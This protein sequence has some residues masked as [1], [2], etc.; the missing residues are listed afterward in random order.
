MLS[1]VVA[2]GIAEVG[3]RIFCLQEVA[4]IRF[5]YDPQRGEIPTPNQKGRQI[6]PG[7]Y[8]FTYSNNSLGLR[9]SPIM[10]FYLAMAPET[11][12][13]RKDGSI[14]HD[15]AAFTAII[16]RQ[17]KELRSLTPVLAASAEPL[18][19]LYFV[20]RDG[21]WTAMG[22]ALEAQYLGAEIERRLQKGQQPG[23]ANPPIFPEPEAYKADKPHYMLYYDNAALL[24]M[25]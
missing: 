7:A 25:I 10:F 18:T 1:L 15:E 13:Y 16:K 17:G 22:Q 24:E 19:K 3:V 12:A 9:G 4:A 20:P 21:H 14:S 23:H 5:V 8:D 2:F 11:E 6:M